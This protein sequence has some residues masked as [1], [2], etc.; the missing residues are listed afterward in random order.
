MYSLR[1]ISPATDRN[2]QSTNYWVQFHASRHMLF[3]IHSTS[4]ECMRMNDMWSPHETANDSASSAR[5]TSAV[6]AVEQGNYIYRNRRAVSAL[7]TCQIWLCLQR[8]AVFAVS[9]WC[10]LY[11]LMTHEFRENNDVT[12][13]E[14]R[15]LIMHSD[16]T[17]ESVRHCVTACTRRTVE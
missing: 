12:E 6:K 15:T 16:V 14:T 5:E 2:R 4:A 11:T 1:V 10:C 8:N 9:V 13:T 17:C 7:I 3:G